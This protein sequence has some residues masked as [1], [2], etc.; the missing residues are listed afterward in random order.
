M[1]L[2]NLSYANKIGDLFIADPEFHVKNEKNILFNEIYTPKF[3]KSKLIKSYKRSVFQLL[4]VIAEIISANVN[5]N[6]FMMIW[7]R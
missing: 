4:R 3:E 1:I 2:N 5:L 6:Q 7:V